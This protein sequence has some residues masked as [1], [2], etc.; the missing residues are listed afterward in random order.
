MQTNKGCISRL[1]FY[2][3]SLMKVRNYYY[4]FYQALSSI[5]LAIIG[6]FCLHKC[7]L[8]SSNISNRGLCSICFKK[9][10]F[11]D[12]FCCKICG[13]KA[14]HED[15]ECVNC[16]FGKRDY[17]LARSLIV[18]DSVSKKI[19]HTFKYNDNFGL[20]K[21]FAN[22]ANARYSE[23]FKVVDCVVPVPMHYLK[24]LIRQYNPA[25]NLARYMAY[26]LKKSFLPN[27]LKKVKLTKTQVNLSK[28]QRYKNLIGS[29]EIGTKCLIQGKNILLIDDVMTT[30]STANLCSKI[31]IQG[32]ALKV[33]VFTVASL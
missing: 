23:I 5:V 6:Y 26:S 10:N 4:K 27:A 24:R 11:I 9:I 21:L 16:V 19:I 30:S 12:D 18:F 17:E 25:N 15:F 28:Q 29:I 3:I 8:C 22:M 31:L 7:L 2:F 33:F 1:I 13:R 20:A 32:G 14:V